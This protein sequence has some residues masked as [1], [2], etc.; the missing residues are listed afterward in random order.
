MPRVHFVKK[1]R[2]DNSAVKKGESYF[3]WKFRYGR[4]QCSKTRPRAS[5]LTQSAYFGTIYS[6][7]EE[8]EDWGGDDSDE[9]GTLVDD[10]R[11]QVC[12]LREETQGSLDNMPESLTYSPTGELLQE[13]IDALDGAESELD[14]VEDFTFDEE[15]FDEDN[16]EADEEEQMEEDRAEHVAN[17]EQRYADEFTDWLN[18]AKGQLTDALDQ[19]IV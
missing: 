7:Q 2:K 19:A 4:K 3:W 14:Y 1:A 13:R 16:Y 6:I 9:F 17:E 10:V 5:Q 8:I 12:E 15:D 11:E 18:E